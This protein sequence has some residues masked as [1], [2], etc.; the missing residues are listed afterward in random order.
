MSIPGKMYARVLTSRLQ[1]IANAKT[2]EEQNRFIREKSCVDQ[3][4]CEKHLAKHRKSTC[5]FD[6]KAY[7]II[8]WKG[9]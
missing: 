7:E 6:E 1:E 9:L 8:G 4:A 3:T 2:T 5:C